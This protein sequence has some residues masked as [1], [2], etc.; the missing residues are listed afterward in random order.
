[1]KSLAYGRRN[2]VALAVLVM[3]AV[4]GTVWADEHLRFPQDIQP[5]FYHS[6]GPIGGLHDGQWVAIPF[7][8]PTESIP[9]D[10]NLLDTFDPQAVGLP[11]LVEGFVRFR[12]NLPMS[13]EARGLGSVPFWF[14][15]LSE[16]QAAIADGALTIAELASLGSRVVG[17]ARFYNEQNHIFGLHKVSHYT[18]VASGT[19][20]DGR[21]FDLLFVEVDLEFVQVQIDF[22]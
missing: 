21:T 22:T 13:W 15:H 6:G 19:L 17:T 11:L 8:R 12:D 7:W 20:D 1:M 9:L 4:A 5:D 10:F 16:F 14:V 18:M 3:L 2:A